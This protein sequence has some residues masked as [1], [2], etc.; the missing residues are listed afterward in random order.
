MNSFEAADSF[1][2]TNYAAKNDWASKQA[3]V[4]QFYELLNRRFR[5]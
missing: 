2:Q 5:V 1:L 4:D 3:T